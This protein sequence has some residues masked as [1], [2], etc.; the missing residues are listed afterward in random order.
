MYFN[1]TSLLKNGRLS[2]KEQLIV[3]KT[4]VFSPKIVLQTK[5][6]KGILVDCIIF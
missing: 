6:K 5:V 1:T 2:L 3:G 4:L